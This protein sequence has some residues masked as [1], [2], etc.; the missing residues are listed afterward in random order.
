MS[1]SDSSVTSVWYPIPPSNQD[2]PDPP[3]QQPAPEPETNPEHPEDEPDHLPEY[4]PPPWPLGVVWVPV[5]DL[6]DQRRV[7]RSRRLS[8]IQAW[9]QLSPHQRCIHRLYRARPNLNCLR[10]SACLA[11]VS[12]PEVPQLEIPSVAR[13]QVP[14]PRP[15]QNPRRAPDPIPRP[16][17]PPTFQE[18]LESLLPKD[19]DC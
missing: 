15:I 14:V 17:T 5:I 4:Q 16:A 12:Q 2:Q 7:R 6:I 11:E 13:R 9:N 19:H 1:E 8:Q 18:L 10:R 3:V